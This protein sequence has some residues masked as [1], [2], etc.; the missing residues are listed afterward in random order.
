[1]PLPNHLKKN[2]KNYLLLLC[3]I[4]ISLITLEIY[5][6]IDYYIDKPMHDLFEK[7]EDILYKLKAGY[8]G[9]TIIGKHLFGENYNVK[10]R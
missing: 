10:I 9:K 2:W 5:S 1:M 7:D 8:N 6:R 3:S 4:L